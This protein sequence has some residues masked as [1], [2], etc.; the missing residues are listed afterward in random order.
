MKFKAHRVETK[1]I[2]ASWNES[3]F[4]DVKEANID[5]NNHTISSVCVFGK[6]ESANGYTYQDAAIN[7]L[8]RMAHGAKWFLDHPSADEKKAR[9]GVRSVRDWGGVFLNPRREGEKVLADLRVRPAYWD[10]AYDVA[11]MQPAGLGNSINSR[12]KV[13]KDDQGKESVVDI[14]ALKSIDLVASAAT[15]SN[16]FESLS[17]TTPE[18]DEKDEADM[19]L[20]VYR[21]LIVE[22]TEG[23]LKDMLQDKEVERKVRDIQWS[24]SDLINEILKDK[25]KD[26]S[27][28]KEEISSIL[29]DLDEE[30][31]SILSGKGGPADAGNGNG[32]SPPDRAKESTKEETEMEFN[33]AQVSLETLTKERPDLIDAVKLSLEDVNRVKVIEDERDELQAALDALKAEAAKKDEALVALQK[34][35]DEMKVKLDVL[36]AKDKKEAKVRLITEKIAGAKLPKEAVTDVWYNDLMCKEVDAIEAAVKDRSD[37]WFTKKPKGLGDEFDPS[38]IKE[39]EESVSDD[40]KIATAK[41]GFLKAVKK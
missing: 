18:E 14:D 8:T 26:F 27:S 21:S 37:L 23:I 5:A 34:A 32:N 41:A 28:K 25:E 33:W 15:T 29:D 20:S 9:D 40:P 6:R 17:D 31:K 12:V 2:T 30:I 13:F 36:D 1:D 35:H 38:K 4:K 3:P 24:A 10:L 11:T 22:K 19:L 7:S 39:V 16:L